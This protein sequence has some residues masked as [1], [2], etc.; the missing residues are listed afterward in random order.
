MKDSFTA[1]SK[2]FKKNAQTIREEYDEILKEKNKSNKNIRDAYIYI[3][4]KKRKNRSHRRKT[5][6]HIDCI[7]CEKTKNTK[8]FSFPINPYLIEILKEKGFEGLIH[9]NPKNCCRVIELLFL[10]AITYLCTLS[11]SMASIWYRHYLVDKYQKEKKYGDNKQ[12]HNSNRTSI[13]ERFYWTFLSQH[14][15]NKPTPYE[16]F[17]NSNEIYYKHY[18]QYA[19]LDQFIQAKILFYNCT[20]QDYHKYKKDR[21]EKLSAEIYNYMTGEKIISEPLIKK[22]T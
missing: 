20:T 3:L 19:I 1:K 2:T 7:H 18:E 9:Y 4:Y 12:K 10:K 11:K 13:K 14:V 6:E 17:M 15:T 21:N 22:N 5:E 8:F 16:E